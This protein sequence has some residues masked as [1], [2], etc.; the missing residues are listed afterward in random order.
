MIIKREPK[1]KLRRI[2]QKHRDVNAAI[3][4]ALASQLPFVFV[5]AFFRE[6]FGWY[7]L[8]VFF[9]MC[10]QAAAALRLSAELSENPAL[11]VLFAFC[12]FA[13]AASLVALGILSFWGHQRLERNGLKPGLLGLDPKAIP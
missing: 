9:V 12:Q 1:K 5:T 10:L 8:A 11:P 13:P 2:A 6:Y 7:L 4:F 3:F